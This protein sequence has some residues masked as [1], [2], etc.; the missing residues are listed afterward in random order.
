MRLSVLIPVYKKPKLAGEIIGKL[1]RNVYPEK[2]IHVV[3]DGKTNPEI[4]EALEPYRERIGIAYNGEQLG[5][6]KSLNE[7]ARGM[8]A[9]GL[10][11]FDN[12]IGLPDDPEF[13]SHVAAQF[14]RHDLMEFPKEGMARAFLGKIAG[15]EFLSTAI[16]SFLFAAIAN[17]CPGM[18]GAAFAIKRDLFERLGGFRYMANEDIDLAF[19]AF[20]GGAKFSYSPKLRVLNHL[21]DD[22]REWLSQRKRWAI[23]N[24]SWFIYNFREIAGNF[25]KDR[26]FRRAAWIMFMP[27]L[28]YS[29]VFVVLKL[30]G[31]T[32]L[33]P[34]IGIIGVQHHFILSLL[35][36]AAHYQMFMDGVIPMLLGFGIT[37]AFNLVLA[38]ILGFRFNLLAFLFYYA[39]YLP[40]WMAVNLFF[41][42][43]VLFG[44]KFKMDWKVARPG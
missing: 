22:F 2:D 39:I 24:V 8:T 10:V 34:F 26:K 44:V 5:K 19:R 7:L 25:F 6:A 18:N 3:V 36:G 17:R 38:R 14:E 43:G 12:D 27:I 32:S 21:P 29:A 40:A 1:L 9:E 20:L 30:L 42:V 23:N 33:Y 41:G 16:S 31:L 11:F 35:I 13:L 37:L 28:L 15:L 4:E